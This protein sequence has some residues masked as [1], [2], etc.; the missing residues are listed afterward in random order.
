VERIPPTNHRIGPLAQQFIADL[1]SGFIGHDRDVVLEQHVLNAVATESGSFRKE[2]KYSPRKV[3]LLACAVI[4]NGARNAYVARLQTWRQSEWPVFRLLSGG[5]QRLIA[6]TGR[7]T[8][9]ANMLA[10][11]APVRWARIA[12]DVTNKYLY[13]AKWDVSTTHFCRQLGNIV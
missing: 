7:R 10:Y 5:V 4:V 3:D 8:I 12:R 6:N 2:K 13:L 1:V 9:Y 11:S